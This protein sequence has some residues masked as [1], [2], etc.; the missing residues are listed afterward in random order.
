M[1]KNN[2]KSNLLAHLKEQPS[3]AFSKN[4][5][6]KIQ[7]EVFLKSELK[8]GL[9]QKAPTNFKANVLKECLPNSV[10]ENYEP[11]ISKKVWYVIGAVFILFISLSFNNSPSQPLIS[12]KYVTDSLNVINISLSVFVKYLNSH[13]FIGLT[14]LGISSLI[15]LETFF[16]LNN[17]TFKKV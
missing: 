10:V 1:K 9:I 2:L 14:L 8:A 3:D 12:T 6:Q 4:V 7:E 5:M 16:K 11:V 15:T 13:S 17:V